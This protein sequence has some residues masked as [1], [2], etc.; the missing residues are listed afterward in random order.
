MPFLALTHLGVCSPDWFWTSQCSHELVFS[1]ETEI[2][3]LY[4]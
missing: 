4:G 2:G 3:N 1:G